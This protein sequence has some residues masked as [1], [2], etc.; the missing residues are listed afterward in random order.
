MSAP[1]CSRRVLLRGAGV[2]GAVGA[3]ALLAGCS[4]GEPADPASPGSSSSGGSSSSSS[5]AGSDAA[6][7]SGVSASEVPVGSAVV[8]QVGGDQVVFAQPVAG[9]FAAYSPVCPH[10]GAIVAAGE[11]TVLVCPL[12]GS[13]FDTADGAAAIQG[14]ADEPLSPLPLTVEGDQLVIG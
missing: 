10:A 14:P 9:E 2:V 12:H 6:P 5:A 8:V 11:G 3:P 13:R 7:A 4:A 1:V